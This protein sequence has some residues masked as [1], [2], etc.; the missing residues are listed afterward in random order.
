MCIHLL[1]TVH[2]SRFYPQLS[3]LIDFPVGE[4][5]ASWDS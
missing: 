1:T 3:S 4:R 2:V 5:I